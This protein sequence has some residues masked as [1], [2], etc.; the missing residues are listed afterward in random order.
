VL[1][2]YKYYLFYYHNKNY[3]LF[4]NNK[5]YYLIFFYATEK[6]EIDFKFINLYIRKKYIIFSVKNKVKYVYN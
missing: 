5:Y 3:I 4:I 1:F 6:Y 2:Y